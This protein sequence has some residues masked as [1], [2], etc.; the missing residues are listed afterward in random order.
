M[1]PFVYNTSVTTK[2][3]V[4]VIVVRLCDRSVLFLCRR[5]STMALFVKKMLSGV[6]DATQQPMACSLLALHLQTALDRF[7][8]RLSLQA[9]QG[10]DWD[11]CQSIK[12]Y[13]RHA[14]QSG[15]S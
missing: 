2:E 3:D 6:I 4:E 12:S 5:V 1:T 11:C 15:C 13:H 14:Q 7:E 9:S 10:E 8:P